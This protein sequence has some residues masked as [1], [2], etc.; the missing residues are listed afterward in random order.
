[1]AANSWLTSADPLRSPPALSSALLL[2]DDVSLYP[3]ASFHIYIFITEA[4]SPHYPRGRFPSLILHWDVVL[5]YKRFRIRII[6]Q[7]VFASI[8]SSFR[9]CLH[10]I[11]TLA[12]TEI[13]SWRRLLQPHNGL[14]SVVIPLAL[15]ASDTLQQAKAVQVAIMK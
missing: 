7:V 11:H 4:Y 3:S 14:I 15:A 12:S 8:P 13:P 10:C 2:F 1:M 6:L 5:T 9:Q